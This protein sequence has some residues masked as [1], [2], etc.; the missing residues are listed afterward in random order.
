MI[1]M[2]NQLVK[3]SFD[4]GV[5]QFF[6]HDLRLS[7]DYV[8]ALTSSGIS[9][10]EF[11]SR[12]SVSDDELIYAQL[13]FRKR[14]K[15]RTQI[16]GALKLTNPKYLLF[17][18]GEFG[19][20]YDCKAEY[21]VVVIGTSSDNLFERDVISIAD[22]NSAEMT[23]DTYTTKITRGSTK[24]GTAIIGGALAGPGGAILGALIG[25]NDNSTEATHSIYNL[26][27]KF[28]NSTYSPLIISFPGDDHTNGR[29][30]KWV[31]IINFLAAKRSRLYARKNSS[32]TNNVT[33]EQLA[34]A[35][36]VK[37]IGAIARA[38]ARGKLTSEEF[39]LKKQELLKSL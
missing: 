2:H 20:G 22:I 34:A 10:P 38:N 11:Q 18:N 37:K 13:R 26:S 39:S 7:F 14:T 8:K 23:Q 28:K 25:K 4:L 30:K 17:G 33:K 27:I 21:I 16:D 1:E 9:V 5:D 36:I 6:S 29:M 24:V 32:E 31:E 15:I 35:E 3:A 19:I 12:T